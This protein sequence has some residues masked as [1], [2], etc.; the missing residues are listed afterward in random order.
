MPKRDA[1]SL[2]CARSRSALLQSEYSARKVSRSGAV[3]AWDAAT[4][5]QVWK[6]T[7]EDRRVFQV[8]AVN[9]PGS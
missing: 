3:S 7:A 5:D 2:T 6:F 8:E 9:P 4:G 1:S